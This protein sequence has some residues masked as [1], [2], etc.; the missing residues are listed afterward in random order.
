V[1]LLNKKLKVWVSIVFLIIIILATGYFFRIDRYGMAKI[2][3]D[4]VVQ[5]NNTKY[6]AEYSA[7]KESKYSK[8]SVES[9]LIGKKIG[10]VK[11]NVSENVGNPYYHFRNGD[12]TFLEVGTEIYSLRS[13]TNSI[14]IKIG[15]EYFLYKTI[16]NN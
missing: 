3:W 8:V 13:G 11:F 4:N 14:S 10:E 5:I 2:H 16:K 9:S 6:Y 1:T 15:A 7:E 12:A